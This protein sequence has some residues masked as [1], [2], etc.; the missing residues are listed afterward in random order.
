MW[1]QPGVVVRGI[2]GE[3]RGDQ[4]D[5]AGIERPVVAADVVEVGD[6]ENLSRNVDFCLPVRR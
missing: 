4:F 1:A 6:P 3:V 5:V 2:V